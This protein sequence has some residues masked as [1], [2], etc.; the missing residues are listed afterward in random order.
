M[1][2]RQ[3]SHILRRPQ[4]HDEIFKLNSKVISNRIRRFH[5][6]FWHELTCNKK[7]S[8]RFST[9]EIT[10]TYINLVS[11]IYLYFRQSPLY[12]VILVDKYIHTF[13]GVLA[14]C[15]SVLYAHPY[16]DCGMRD[17][18]R[19]SVISTAMVRQY[20][21]NGAIKNLKSH[22]NLSHVKRRQGPY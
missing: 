20:C 9:Y 4:K 10:F 2:M 1:L 19:K 14:E 7:C 21:H 6:T 8:I 5:K 17:K 22:L 18:L 13:D 12:H 3:S 15:T 16:V 11:Y